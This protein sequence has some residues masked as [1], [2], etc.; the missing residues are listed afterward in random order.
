[1][2]FP[3][4]AVVETQY[5]SSI[6]ARSF[7]TQQRQIM[8]ALRHNSDNPPSLKSTFFYLKRNIFRLYLFSLS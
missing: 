6:L 5:L 3:S 7:I 2:Q 8:P 4:E 1:M